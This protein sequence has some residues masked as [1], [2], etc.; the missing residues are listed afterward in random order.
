MIKLSLE[1]WIRAEKGE[2]PAALF[3]FAYFFFLR[4]GYYILRPVRDEMGIRGG[5]SHLPWLF[6]GTFLAI[7]AAVPLYAVIA[8]R[9]PVR[10]FVPLVYRFF[11]ANLFLFWLLFLWGQKT[12]WVARAF[13]I[14]TSVFNLFVVSVFWS[15]MVDLFKKEQ[16]D[17]LFGFIAGGG[18]LGAITGPLLAL[19]LVRLIGT[20]NLLLLSCLFLELT[21]IFIYLLIQRSGKKEEVTAVIGGG[22]L[23]GIKIVFRSPYLLMIALYIFLMTTGSTFLYLAQAEI[24]SGALRSSNDRT[25]VF[26]LID[27]GVNLLT[28]LIQTFLTGRIITSLGLTFALSVLPAATALGLAALGFA[29]WLP[30]MIFIQMVGRALR[31]AITHPAREILFTVVSR[32]EK[33]KSKNFMDTAV[34]RGGDAASA[35]F[36]QALKGLL[37][38]TPLLWVGTL[39]SVIWLSVGIYLGKKH[40]SI[41]KKSE[42]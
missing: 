19:S 5:I 21:V 39:I 42:I 20:T 16:A 37:A 2:L 34:Y 1:K 18:T 36:F 30:L 6:T 35:W 8:S 29:P 32:E 38:L 33:Y 11:N 40:L 9:Y 28:L 13:F 15:F 25:F 27:F 41:Q 7:L 24:V 14:W 31:Y 23:S 22:V 17:R 3:S 10:K 26:A 12:E 4:S